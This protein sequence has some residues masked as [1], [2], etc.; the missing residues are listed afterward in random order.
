MPSEMPKL[1]S[2]TGESTAV[3]AALD[4]LRPLV[5]DYRGLS[6]LLDRSISTLERMKAARKLPPSVRMGNSCKWR[7]A[8]IQLWLALDCPD[9]REFIARKKLAGH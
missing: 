5:V 2:P 4:E 6:K 7:V 3:E 8:D 1:F 9:E